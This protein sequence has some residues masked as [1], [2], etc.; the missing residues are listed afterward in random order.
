MVALIIAIIGVFTPMGQKMVSNTVGAISNGVDVTTTNFTSLSSVN[1][2][3]NG[4]VFTT[5]SRPAAL[6]Q[7]T[8]TVC[9]ILSPS[10]TSTLSFGSFM[11][12]SSTAASGTNT[13]TRITMAK[14][15]TPYATTTTVGQVTYSSPIQNYPLVAST[16]ATL[17]T[18]TNLT[19]PPSTYF[20]V[21]VEGALGYSMTGDCQATFTID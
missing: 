5:S 11:F 16:T 3:S 21:G 14:S 7:A 15:S 1:G 8:T 13:T 19:F 12:S 18:D 4:G 2:I 20:V 17:G 6:T 10:S 9:A